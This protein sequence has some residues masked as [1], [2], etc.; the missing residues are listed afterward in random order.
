MPA[1]KHLILSFNE[2]LEHV[3]HD[4]RKEW[5]HPITVVLDFQKSPRMHLFW[6]A[7]HHR[8]FEQGEQV[9]GPLYNN[10]IS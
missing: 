9:H 3:K 5:P 7:R 6:L 4:L 1:L 8:M 10:L 2:L